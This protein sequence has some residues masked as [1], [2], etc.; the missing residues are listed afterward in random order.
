MIQTRAGRRHIADE[1]NIDSMF[2]KINIDKTDP[3]TVEQ[4][5]AL[6]E[7]LH[8]VLTTLGSK[9]YSVIFLGDTPT[10][11]P[12]LSSFINTISA[13]SSISAVSVYSTQ[14]VDAAFLSALTKTAINKTHFVF[15]YDGEP[16]EFGSF[17]SG[18]DVINSVM[19]KMPTVLFSTTPPLTGD[20]PFAPIKKETDKF[21]FADGVYYSLEELEAK[22]GAFN[23]YGLMCTP[24][25]AM[26]PNSH[27]VR[28]RPACAQNETLDESVFYTDAIFDHLK[29]VVCEQTRCNKN[30]MLN[31]KYSLAEYK[32]L[33][34]LNIL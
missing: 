28:I 13:L 16:A 27:T 33:K 25:L 34:D 20:E 30:S 19:E 31:T 7:R 11:H 6:A 1:T 22:L 2:I 14:T 9:R 21:Y 32:R 29:P 4:F 5:T 23:F 18:I 10:A 17:T 3:I 24:L 8:T 12:H 26:Y 15:T